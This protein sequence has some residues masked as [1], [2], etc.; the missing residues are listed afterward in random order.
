MSMQVKE[1]LCLA[2]SSN[3]FSVK[4]KTTTTNITKEITALTDITDTIW[5]LSMFCVYSLKDSFNA[6]VT[7]PLNNPHKFFFED[8]LRSDN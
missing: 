6:D 8:Y 3:K 1:L 5:K 2:T 4:T 7:R